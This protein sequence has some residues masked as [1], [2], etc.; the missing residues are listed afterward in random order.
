MNNYKDII[1]FEGFYKINEYGNIISLDRLCS[2]KGGSF[3]LRKGKLLKPSIDRYGYKKTSLTDVNG[4]IKY[5]TIHRLVAIN[6]INNPDNKKT[7]NH[8]DGNK[9]NNHKDNL[10][11]NTVSEQNYHAYRCNLNSRKGELNNNSK[12]TVENIKEIRSLI[13]LKTTKELSEKFK[14]SKPHI[15]NIKNNKVWIEN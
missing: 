6:F 14:I 1:G 15:R 13:D 3:Q 11:W 12:L 7:V 9:L 2:T 5:L 4:K 8:I 10:E